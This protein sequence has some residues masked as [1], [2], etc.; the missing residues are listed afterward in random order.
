MTINNREGYHRELRRAAFTESHPQIIDALMTNHE[1]RKTVLRMA[2]L[3]QIGGSADRALDKEIKR[4][5]SLHN[6]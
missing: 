1:F 4:M 6:K 3:E 2:H 5:E